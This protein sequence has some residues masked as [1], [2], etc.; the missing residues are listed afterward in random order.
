[1]QKYNKRQFLEKKVRHKD[2][3]SLKTYKQKFLQPIK[4]KYFLTFKYS[5]LG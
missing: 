1:M 5:P 4:N 2:E 3:I